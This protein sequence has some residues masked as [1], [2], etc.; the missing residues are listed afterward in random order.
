MNHSGIN[1]AADAIRGGR[2]RLG[3]EL[4]STRIKACLIGDDPRDV[5]A[6]GSFTWENS[7]EDGL[8]TYSLEDV[9]S[10]VQAAYADLVDDA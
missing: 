3:I 2:G 5:L 1:G 9:W 4:G 6:V 7:F 8:W 10:G